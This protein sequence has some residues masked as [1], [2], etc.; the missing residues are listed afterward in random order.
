MNA[1]TEAE[2]HLSPIN[3][4]GMDAFPLAEQ[5]A[6]QL[7]WLKIAD[8]VVD[9]RYQRPLNTGNWAAI[10]RIAKDFR[11]SRFSPVLVA[12]VE[13]GRYA[14]IDGQ[15]R[16]HAA[17]LCGIESSPAMVALVPPPEQALAFIEINT[18]QIRVGGHA[19]YRAALTAGEPWAIACCDAVAQAGCHLMTRNNVPKNDKKPGQI[20]A[21]GLIRNLVAAGHRRAV[22]EGLAALREF[23]PD[24]VANFTDTL[25]APWLSACAETPATRDDYLSALR[26]KRPWL[27]LSLADRVAEDTKQPK[28]AARR[29]HFSLLIRR[30]RTT[31]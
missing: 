14:V 17:A 30:E 26:A 25:L 24:A 4:D 5:P 27:V 8:L 28:A 9:S 6:P 12:P 15:H 7:L 3:V 29:E 2:T 31:P 23:D 19:V 18:R 16:A 22:T 13:G 10:R 11:W 20:F 21:V 1:N